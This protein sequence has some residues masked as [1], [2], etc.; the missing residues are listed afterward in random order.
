MILAHRCSQ[1]IA[2]A[3]EQ[4]IRLLPSLDGKKQVP[5]N[6]PKH[7]FLVDESENVYV[8]L[9]LSHTMDIS[10]RESVP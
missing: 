7:S 6:A 3:Q 5:V 1:T 10:E 9:F 2:R 4:K 8:A